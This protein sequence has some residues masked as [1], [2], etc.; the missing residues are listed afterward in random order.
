MNLTT[1]RGW[2]A[3]LAGSLLVIAVAIGFLFAVP[4]PSRAAV[5]PRNQKVFRQEL[6]AKSLTKKA[7]EAVKSMAEQTWSLPPEA[8]E[9]KIL[10]RVTAIG[11][12][13]HLEVSR[14]TVSH[15]IPVAGLVAVRAVATLEGTFPDALDAIRALERPEEKLSVTDVKI[16]TSTN[17]GKDTLTES[18]TTVISLAGFAAPTAKEKS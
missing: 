17:S 9:T 13:H 11:A 6:L 14:F 4:L 12:K 15:P 1:L 8:L 10:D 3:L 2:D 5:G 18:V 7:D 16:D